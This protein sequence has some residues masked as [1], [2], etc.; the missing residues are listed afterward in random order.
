MSGH[1]KW[2]NIKH[3]KEKADA[4]KAKIFTKIGKE[5]AVAIKAGGPDPNNNSKLRDLIAKA[6]ANNVPN[7]NIQRT[8]KK[9]SDNSDINFEEITYEGYGPSGVAI[10]VETSTDNR[11][12]TAGNVRA[13]FSKYG[14]NLGQNGCVS[15]LF[16]EKGVITIMDE[17]GEIEEDKIMEDALESGAEDLKS[18][19]GEYTIYTAVEDLDAVRD[20]IVALGYTISTADVA[21]V[22]ST[23]VELE[24]EDDV[25]NME[26]MLDKFNE[27]DDV[28]AVYTNWDN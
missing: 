21:K 10:I 2:N 14:G 12:R 1:S 23:Y 27:D 6:K 16:E 8:I 5:M 24:N 20:A 15:Y 17:D 22:P 11:N 25:E 4:A 13:W 18:D 9:F 28:N 19:E 3:K 26:K 7:E